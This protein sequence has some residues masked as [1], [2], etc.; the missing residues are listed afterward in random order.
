[1]QAD[2]IGWHAFQFSLAPSPA[3]RPTPWIEGPPPE[4]GD[5]WLQD[6]KRAIDR[7]SAAP[8]SQWLVHPGSLARVIGRRYGRKAPF[9]ADEWRT[10]HGDLN[11]SNVTAPALCLLDWE[12]W[13]AAPRGFDI[14]MLLSVT[15]MQ[16]EL[17][18]RI[19]RT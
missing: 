15:V 7:L 18:R 3:V 13:G 11:W 8:L 1:W 9:E 6:L 19:E 14:A 12:R 17:Y 4:I 5:G 2:G 16:P 10:A